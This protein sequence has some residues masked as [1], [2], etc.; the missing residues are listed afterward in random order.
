MG[1]YMVIFGMFFS[2]FVFLNPSD[3]ILITY[4]QVSSTLHGHTA[5]AVLP[6]LVSRD[7]G[8]WITFL[9]PV[10]SL[11]YLQRYRSDN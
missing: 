10:F 5:A 8:M 7:F 9:P 4:I 1:V 3:L 2:W 11:M 6:T